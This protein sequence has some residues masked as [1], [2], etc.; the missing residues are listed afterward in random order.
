[1]ATD[2][3]FVEYI[4]DQLHKTCPVTFKKM[5]GEY[6]IYCCGKV[7]ALV[8]DNRLYVKPTPGGLALAGD[9]PLAPAYPGAKPGLLIADQID[10]SDW[11]GQLIK[12]TA[13]E[14][15]EPK[16]KKPKLKKAERGR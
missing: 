1:M 9:L 12:I 14:L 5:F 4:A 11:L 13:Q 16:P 3:G 10:D 15:P 2:L 7:V 8:C 6:A